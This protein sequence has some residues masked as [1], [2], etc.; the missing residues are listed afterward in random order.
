MPSIKVLNIKADMPTVDVARR[1]LIEELK[2]A[3][4]GGF[5]AVKLIHGYGSTGTGG[6]LRGALRSSL[7]RRRK[8]GLIRSFVFGER[9]DV[10]DPAARELLEACPELGRDQD[11]ARGNEGVTL[12]LL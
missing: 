12:I 7:A 2:A 8:E 10:F 3:R 1:R 6:A 5:T 11:L 9:W 4:R